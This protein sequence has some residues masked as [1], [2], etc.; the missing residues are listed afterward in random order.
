MKLLTPQETLRA[1]ADGKKIEFAQTGSLTWRTFHPKG[2]TI[3]I[4]SVFNRSFVFRLAQEMITISNVSFPKPESEPLKNGT[5]Y[6]VAEPSYL[7]YMEAKSSCWAD[8]DLDRDFLHRGLVHLTKENAI[9][10]AKALI[11][12]SGG[13]VDD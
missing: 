12:L 13:K 11:K 1:I 8:D 4:R 9:A 10:H 5:E 2:S 6:W 7:R 3:C